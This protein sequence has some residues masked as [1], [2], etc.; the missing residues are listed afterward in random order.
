[1]VFLCGPRR[2]I[3]QK[4]ACCVSVLFL[5]SL[6]TSC[7]GDKGASGPG[8]LVQPQDEQAEAAEPKELVAFAR[9]WA[10]GTRASV[11]LWPHE[12]R[13]S[14]FTLREARP[15]LGFRPTEGENSVALDVQP[16]LGHEVQLESLEWSWEDEWPSNVQVFLSEAC[17][18]QA[19][20]AF[21]WANPKD[22]LL[23]GGTVAGCSEIHFTSRGTGVLT[24]LSLVGR[25][26]DISKKQ[27]VTINGNSKKYPMFGVIEG[28][29]GVPWSWQERR[30][31]IRALAAFGLGSYLYAP[32]DDPLHRARWREPYPEE[33]M[34]R[35]QDW[36]RE[37]ASL[38]V[39]IFFGIS[40]F[41]DGNFDSGSDYET[42]R[43]KALQFVERGFEGFA[44]LADDIEFET[45]VEVDGAL[46]EKHCGV[47]N[48]L[49]GDLRLANPQVKM[50]F[51]PTVYS[52][53]RLSQWAGAQAYLEA[54]RGLD[55]SVEVMWTGKG[56]SCAKM[57]PEDLQ[58][59]QALIGRNPLIW[60]NFWAN[61]GGDIFMGR[62]LLAPFSGRPAN[63]LQ[64]VVGITH[65]PM[66]HG[67]LSRLVLGTFAAWLDEPSLSMAALVEKAI[68]SEQEFAIGLSRSEEADAL[69]L[70]L[71]FMAFQ[72]NA[73][74]PYPQCKAL[75]DAVT[76]LRSSIKQSGLPIAQA[77][78]LLSVLI[79]LWALPSYLYHSGLDPELVDEAWFPAEKARA[80]AE[81]GLWVMAGLGER[82]A[83]KAGTEALQKAHEA[84]AKS[85]ANRFMFGPATLA[86]F[87]DDIE[88]IKPENRGFEAPARTQA[89]LPTCKVAHRASWKGW[90]E[91]TKVEAQGLPEMHIEQDG[92]ITWSARHAGRYEGA[93]IAVS[94]KGWD[95][96]IIEVFCSAQ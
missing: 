68:A 87:L 33:E 78:T 92:T 95:F 56:T 35:F 81:M 65:N 16:W 70:R 1:M 25:H 50:W 37:A 13:D 5:V 27:G 96:Q 94:E 32:K 38:G 18:L 21:N 85:M 3:M 93:A 11:G 46:G 39:K 9:L 49:L 47:V 72:G 89:A 6:H 8:D 22:A 19:K 42:L 7:A 44:L 57:V 34:A 12:A 51:V 64:V 23:L 77:T 15:G 69:A 88:K 28:F 90:V 26:E 14:I 84:K 63:L 43:A 82:L 75:E 24:R 91:A 40:P 62:I 30:N 54:L 73:T 48:R 61:D 45:Q 71:L 59:V 4:F 83:G 31:M 67:A 55:S 20:A 41:I 36:N 80:E 53:E 52:D 66:M 74:D 17:G 79:K 29:Y 58:R 10:K 60:D 76:A 2:F 86:A